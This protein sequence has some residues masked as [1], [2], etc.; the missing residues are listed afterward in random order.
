M[1]RETTVSLI[2]LGTLQPRSNLSHPVLHS[3]QAKVPFHSSIDT[4]TRQD[5]DSP[6][7]VSLSRSSLDEVLSR[8][9]W[10]LA[11]RGP[12]S[13]RSSLP[14][15]NDGRDLGIWSR[16]TLQVIK[17]CRERQTLVVKSRN[18]QQNLNATVRSSQ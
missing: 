10:L 17:L 15:I 11:L 6:Q 2:N 7:R 12:S 5:F 3:Q 16:F 9:P 1:P 8:L 4:T 14:L 18:R 13:S